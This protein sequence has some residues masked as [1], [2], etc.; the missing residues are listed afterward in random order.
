MNRVFLQLQPD[1]HREG[2]LAVSLPLCISCVLAL[3]SVSFPFLLPI[4]FYFLSI[5]GVD[6]RNAKRSGYIVSMTTLLAGNGL[7]G[8][9]C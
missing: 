2:A 3:L 8:W 6:H 1:K 5:C 9:A 7:Y 4:F